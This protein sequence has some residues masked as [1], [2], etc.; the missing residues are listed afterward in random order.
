MISDSK[1][2]LIVVDNSNHRLH[3]VDSNGKFSQFLLTKDDGIKQPDRVFFD[4]ASSRLY[5]AHRGS[6][7]A[8]VRVYRWPL[9]PLSGEVQNTHFNL[10]LN[11]CQ[12]T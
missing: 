11:L 12:L 6:K 2:R 7:C 4:E 5:V 1:G 10:K 9:S 8:E 3:L